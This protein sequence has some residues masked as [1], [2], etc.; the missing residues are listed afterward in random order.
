MGCVQCKI[1]DDQPGIIYIFARKALIRRSTTSSE[2]PAV[3]MLPTC[4]KPVFNSNALILWSF[5]SVTIGGDMHVT[6][7]ANLP[8]RSIYQLILSDD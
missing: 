8:C 2:E 7:A 1:L 3:I 4:D 6:T 5:D